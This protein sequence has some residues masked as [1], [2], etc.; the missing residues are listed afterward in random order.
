[1]KFFAFNHQGKADAYI[2]ALIQ[3]GYQ[4]ELDK[5]N[6]Q[7][8]FVITDH[9]IGR[10]A[11]IMQGMKHR[12]VNK[13]FVIP[14]A[15]RPNLYAD[16]FKPWDFTTCQFVSAP[17]HVEIMRSYGYVGKLELAGWSFC[18]IL[19][20]KQNL[21]PYQVLF[22]PIHPRNAPIDQ[23]VNRQVFDKL[24]ELVRQGKIN[25]TIRWLPPF[26]QNN[27]D[28]IEGIG[29]TYIEGGLDLSVEQID[30]A[31]LV[32]SHQTF[33]YLAVARG[34]PTI[35]MGEHIPAHTARRD[36]RNNKSV[37]NWEKYQKMLAYPIDIL[38]DR[39]V[40]DMIYEAGYG[41]HLI[42]DWKNRMIGEQFDPNTF[43]KTLESYL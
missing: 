9:D 42:L 23:H 12:G 29:I 31:D 20:F 3:A 32:V 2:G 39:P 27:I 13:F 41:G 33:A 35:M 7:I 6:R 18:K 1:M 43:V 28:R 15:A 25:L 24:V 40:M 10:R 22:A 8:Q 38:D 19:P 21:K 11:V 16:I 36:N 26:E 17:A 37:N 14:H 5:E 4:L 30:Q 34:V